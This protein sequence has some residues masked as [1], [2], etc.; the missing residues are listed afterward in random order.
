MPTVD[1][2]PQD[3]QW[4]S[5]YMN[6][7]AVFTYSDWALE[8]LAEQG[9][10]RCGRVL[11]PAGGRPRRLPAGRRPPRPP[12]SDGHRRGL[13]RRRHGDAEPAAQALPGPVEAFALFLRKR[14][15]A[16]E[17]VPV[18]AHGWPDVG[19]DIPRLV[20]RRASGQV[21]VH[22]LCK[23]C[24]AAFPSF[25]R[26][27]GRPAAAAA[28]PRRPSPTPRGRE[29]GGVL[30]E[31]MNL[32]DVYVQYANSEGFGMPQVE[33]AAC[34]VPVMAVDYS[35]MSDVVRKLAG[36]PDPR[37]A[38]V[39]GAGDALLAGPA[40]QRGL[41]LP[42][43]RS[44]CPAR[45]GPR[46][47][48]GTRPARRSRRTT[49]R[50]DRP[51]WEGPPRL[52]AG[53]VGGV[54]ARSTARP[55]RVP[56][57]LSRR[58]VRPLGYGPCGGPPRPPQQLHGPPHDPRPQLGPT[59]PNT[60]GVYFNE[61]STPWARR[62]A[63]AAVQPRRRPASDLLRLCEQRNHWERRRAERVRQA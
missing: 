58:G 62:S 44:S 35:A 36:I 15:R 30:A 42:A 1:A 38:D 57:G 34:G 24:G 54:W 39:P 61:A 41:R 17:D 20:P 40:R 16:A 25:F 7:D 50:P 46:A 28:S 33:A 52:R 22:L 12:P 31:V 3:E 2:A 48:W 10:P 59:L 43:D 6:A 49:L 47:Q 8:V 26:T 9:G 18:P 63:A 13:P 21:P 53:P 5:T 32:F 55:T 45:A 4:L 23:A 14:P 11:R 19:W 27:P 56:A 51:A 29:Q 37:G 60:G